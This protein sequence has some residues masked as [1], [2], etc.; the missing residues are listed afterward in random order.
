VVQG[1]VFPFYLEKGVE[2]LERLRLHN[3]KLKVREG[4]AGEKEQPLT[5]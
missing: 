5:N 4:P 2:G 3:N 1:G